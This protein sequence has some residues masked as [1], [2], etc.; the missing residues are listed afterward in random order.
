MSTKAYMQNTLPLQGMSTQQTNVP[1]QL[2]HAIIWWP[3]RTDKYL[4]ELNGQGHKGLQIMEEP[5]QK[6]PLGKVIEA[7]NAITPIGRTIS[8]GAIKKGNQSHYCNYTNVPTS[9]HC[10]DSTEI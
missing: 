10:I 9:T 6:G 8:K 4:P 2:R 1:V 7:I 5:F 3:S